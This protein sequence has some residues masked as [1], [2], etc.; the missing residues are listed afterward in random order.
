[1]NMQ[2]IKRIYDIIDEDSEKLAKEEAAKKGIEWEEKYI[3]PPPINSRKEANFA[4]LLALEHNMRNEMLAPFRINPMPPYEQR[5]SVEN[6]I[7]A[8]KKSVT[9][10]SASYSILESGI[11]SHYTSDSLK[12][13]ADIKFKEMIDRFDLTQERVHEIEDMILNEKYE[14]RYR[15]WLIT[16][17]IDS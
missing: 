5:E 11:E 10:R 12:K 9:H 6:W 14:G 2:K 1:M 8:L 15:N 13:L 3:S 4:Y 7:K 17:K 16:S